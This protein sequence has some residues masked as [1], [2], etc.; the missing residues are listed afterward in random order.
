MRRQGCLREPKLGS[1]ARS[2]E[3][4]KRNRTYYEEQVILSISVGL[5]PAPLCVSRCISFILLL[6]FSAEVFS[7]L[8]QA[9][10]SRVA[11]SV[12]APHHFSDHIP[13]RVCPAASSPYSRIPGKKLC[14]HHPCLWIGFPCVRCLLFQLTVPAEGES[15]KEQ[16][17]FRLPQL[18]VCPIPREEE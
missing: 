11:T 5:C 12:P 1:A 17:S 4:L 18:W 10:R 6:S 9:Q 13:N 15:H 8:V 2:P 16:S 14:W 3:T 7:L